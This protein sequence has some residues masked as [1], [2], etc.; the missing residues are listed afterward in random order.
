[1]DKEKVIDLTNKV[2]RQTLL[3]PKKE[4]LRYKIRE[5]ADDFLAKFISGRLLIKK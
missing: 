3:F 5:V 2:Y 1:M 4:P